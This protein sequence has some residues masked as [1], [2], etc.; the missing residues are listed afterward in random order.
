MFIA[1]S[2][3]D[4]VAKQENTISLVRHVLPRYIFPGI[5]VG[6]GLTDLN[7]KLRIDRGILH[8]FPQVTKHDLISNVIRIDGLVHGPTPVFL[9]LH[10][11]WCIAATSN[12]G[13]LFEPGFT[14]W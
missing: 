1:D 11:L 4:L 13:V 5:A 2:C 9:K 10:A 8:P 7:N 6:R 12:P 3:Q 14:R